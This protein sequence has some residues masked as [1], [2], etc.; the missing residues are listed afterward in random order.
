M[1]PTDPPSQSPP[2]LDRL[3]LSRRAKYLAN[4]GAEIGSAVECRVCRKLLRR[5]SLA[6]HILRCH[7]AEVAA[8]PAAVFD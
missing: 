4:R 5:S 6:A 3:E 8:M 7:G 2:A 1:V